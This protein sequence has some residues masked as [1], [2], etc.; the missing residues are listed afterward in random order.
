MNA[1][2]PNLR[3]PL[4]R[5]CRLQPLPQVEKTRQ[6]PR[7]R[8]V[9]Y[10]AFLLPRKGRFPYPA[11]AGEPC[12]A[13]LITEGKRPLRSEAWQN[14]RVALTKRCPATVRRPWVHFEPLGLACFGVPKGPVDRANRITCV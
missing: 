9:I 3:P 7:P 6:R 1:G 12:I 2:L 11:K 10:G 8:R 13:P 14:R 5:Q 4:N